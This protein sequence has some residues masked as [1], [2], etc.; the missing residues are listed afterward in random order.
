MSI[1]KK[2]I[3]Q[4]RRSFITAASLATAAVATSQLPN[5][6]MA[7]EKIKG[8]PDLSSLKE[9]NLPGKIGLGGVAAGNGFHENTDDQI[10]QTLTGA[11]DAGMR[12]FDTSPFYGFGL[13]ERR[14]GHFLFNKD[15]KDF[16]L[17]T[18][19]G[20]VFQGDP[21]F[22][23]DPAS[24]WHGNLNFK[25]KYDYTASGVRRSVEDS[26]QRLGLSSI[27]FV[28]VHDLSPDTPDMGPRWLEYFEIAAKGAFPEL[29]KMREEGII[30]GWGMGVNTPDPIL[31][32]LEVADPDI[33]LVATQYSLVDH[34]NALNKLFSAMQKKNVQAV[35]GAPINAGFLA[36]KERFN[37]GPT[38]PA[39]MLDKRNKIQLIAQKYN[40]PLRTVALQFAAAH[41]I[42][43]AVIPGSSTA[44]QAIENAV[45]MAHRI[46]SALWKDLKDQKLIASDAP[47]PKV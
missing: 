32:S 10:E 46:P 5:I 36:G 27:D 39:E 29:T 33:M 6:A 24:L 1:E 41:P 30:K 22:K 44:Q 34:E 15:R 35:I 12:Y 43:Y 19:I 26:L 2:I 42:V 9:F 31:K 13:S 23:K 18:K 45:S 3:M 47:V 7:Q 40:V 37:Y 38:I 25:Y 11:W 16:V 14:F 8:T 28:F 21:N 4:S 17:S 20:R